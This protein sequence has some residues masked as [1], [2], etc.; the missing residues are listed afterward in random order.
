VREFYGALTADRRAIKGILITTSAFTAQ[1]AKFAEGLPIE[2]VARDK[3]QGL[4]ERHGLLHAA[5]PALH[6]LARLHGA[7]CSIFES[8]AN[9]APANSSLAELRSNCENMAHAVTFSIRAATAFA[10]GEI[11]QL[12][13]RVPQ[14][15]DSAIRLHEQKTDTEAIKLLR[16]AAQL[17][18]ENPDVWLWLGICYNSVGLHD[19]QIAALREAVRLKPDFHNAWL[20]LGIG[21]H[22]VGDLDGAINAVTRANTIPPDDA[23]AWNELG[24]IYS[25]KGVEEGANFAFRK[26]VKIKPDF[27]RGWWNLGLFQYKHGRN[28][29]ALSAFQEA[30]R[31]DPD[32][33][34]SWEWLVRVC[35]RTGDPARMQNALNRLQQLDPAKA[36]ELRRELRV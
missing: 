1:A 22:C 13:D 15:L 29:E 28:S 2:L 33:T 7:Y 12:K 21:L 25:D 30:L 10:L 31:T 9:L 8:L 14:L 36:R 5:T 19:D 34:L 35:S 27:V 16:E 18:P 23:F 11:P 20:W 32:D 24:T 3:L 26:A 4:L 17:Q 6:P